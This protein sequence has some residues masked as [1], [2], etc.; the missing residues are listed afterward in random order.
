MFARR[1][2]G[3]VPYLCRAIFFLNW[4]YL[5]VYRNCGRTEIA[6]HTDADTCQ[7]YQFSSAASEGLT[8]WTSDITGC[9]NHHFENVSDAN[10]LRRF[11][12]RAWFFFSP[13]SVQKEVFECS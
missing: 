1:T 12:S 10:Q 11:L 8:V 4:R 5:H 13:C 7:T 2:S 9:K 6:L 3:H